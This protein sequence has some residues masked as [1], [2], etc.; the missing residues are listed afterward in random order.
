MV[1]RVFEPGE[2]GLSLLYC[3]FDKIKEYRGYLIAT[4]KRVL[5]LTPDL[6]FMDKFRYQTIL[7]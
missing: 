7:M 4:N 1:R 2:Q 5:F 6:Q 3:E